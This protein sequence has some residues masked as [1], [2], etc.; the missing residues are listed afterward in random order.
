MF[1]VIIV[2]L[3]L[4]ELGLQGVKG[5]S[6][7]RS[8]RL[9]SLFKLLNKIQLKIKIFLK[10]RVFKLAKSWPTLNRLI[11]IIGKTVGALGNLTFV[12][13]INSFKF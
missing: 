12:L 10:L 9:V 8:F 11:M 5:L 13:G 1:D 7:L 3:S 2:V 4:V 6:V